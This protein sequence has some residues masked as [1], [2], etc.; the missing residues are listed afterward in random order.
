VAQIL[1]NTDEHRAQE[2]QR[3]YQALLRRDVDPFALNFLVGFLRSGGTMEQVRIYLASSQEY[4]DRAGGTN[5]AFVGGLYQDF[6]GR[7]ADPGGRAFF[8]DQ[9]TRGG[10]SRV[11]AA[12]VLATSA[13][14]RQ[15]N[16]NAL[17]QRYVS[18][19]ADPGAL[20][21]FSVALARG[22]REETIE[23]LLTGSD[24]YF[25]PG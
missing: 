6:L 8:T 19:Q 21:A 23:F 5:D 20:S 11:T 15:F 17:F 16:V 2:V 14:G 4:F 18:R 1:T 13:E 22:L 9:L 24:E 10:L 25:G 3:A 12:V 7:A